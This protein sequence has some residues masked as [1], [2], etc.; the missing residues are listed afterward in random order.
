VVR[1]VPQ[2]QAVPMCVDSGL[3]LSCLVRKFGRV[4]KQDCLGF[5]VWR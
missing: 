2:S 3:I 1:S 4:L 5:Y